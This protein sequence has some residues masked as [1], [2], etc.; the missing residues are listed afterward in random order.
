M[1]LRIILSSEQEPRTKNDISLNCPNNKQILNF[2][3][4]FGNLKFTKYRC[5]TTWQT[6]V[7]LSFPSHQ[8]PEIMNFGRVASIRYGNCY[9]QSLKSLNAKI[10]IQGDTYWD[11]Y[12]QIIQ[13]FMMK[14]LPNQYYYQKF[15]HTQFYFPQEIEYNQGG[16]LYQSGGC[17]KYCSSECLDCQEN[18]NT[19]S[20]YCATCPLNYYLQPI[21]M[22]AESSCIRQAE[23]CDIC[24]IRSEDEIKKLNPYFLLTDENKQYSYKCVRPV[25]N[26][27]VIID[28]YFQIAKY[29]YTPF[30]NLEY[31]FTLSDYKLNLVKQLNIQYCNQIGLQV[32]KFQINLPHLQR[33]IPHFTQVCELKKYIFSLQVLK[34]EINIFFKW[35]S[36]TNFY[37]FDYIEIKNV[38]FSQTVTQILFQNQNQKVNLILIDI[39]IYKT[40][41]IISILYLTQNYQ[42]I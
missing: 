34:I 9:N 13:N 27:N 25:Q 11:A 37:G 12:I 42:G 22:Q 16:Q 14:L 29:C 30:C 1:Y 10:L 15:Q 28:S 39:L 26:Q 3:G 7:R 8:A 2:M 17:L 24:Q 38:Y 5:A 40:L 33:E 18:K 20:F 21:R 23:L 35:G 19:P 31:I 32:K 4:L 41:I 6:L 36:P